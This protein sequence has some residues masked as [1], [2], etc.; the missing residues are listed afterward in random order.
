LLPQRPGHRTA[1][2]LSG[3]VGAYNTYIE[4]SSAEL[5]GS[6]P[7]ALLAIQAVLSRL[8]V[9]A[10]ENEGRPA[11]R[12]VDASGLA[13]APPLGP[14][15][16]TPPDVPTERAT[17]VCVVAADGLRAIGAIV[18]ASGDTFVATAGRRV[19]LAEAFPEA[20]AYAA[21]APWF[22]R[23][24]ALNVNGRRYV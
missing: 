21:D 19:P 6:P 23:T 22:A 7:D 8:V 18:L 13:C 17:V 5:L 20:I 15:P 11:T 2:Q 12:T 10:L 14:R 24:D 9:A 4:A 3:V 1:T 16:P